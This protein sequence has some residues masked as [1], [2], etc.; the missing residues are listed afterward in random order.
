[1]WGDVGR[2]GEMW[3]DMG[4][5]IVLSKVR[6]PHGMGWSIHS[7]IHSFM[8]SLIHPLSHSLQELE[9]MEITL[10]AYSKNFYVDGHVPE[11]H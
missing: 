8:H 5:Q 11:P 9:G 1:M 10:P 2:Y 7:F 6:A 3:G 4:C